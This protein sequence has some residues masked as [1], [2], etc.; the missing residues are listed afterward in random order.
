ML[1]MVGPGNLLPL[2]MIVFGLLAIPAI[3]V[4]RPGA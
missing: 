1:L 4:A 2:G 3:A